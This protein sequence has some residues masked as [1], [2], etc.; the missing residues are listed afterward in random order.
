M[1]IRLAPFTLRRPPVL[2]IVPGAAAQRQIASLS[3]SS[4]RRPSRTTCVTLPSDPR[5]SR[6]TA[7]PL[8]AHAGMLL[9][10]VVS[11]L[12]ALVLSIKVHNE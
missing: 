10:A 11:F 5:C 7:N 1:C 8:S 9:R 2:Q 6:A 12:S 4:Y 3:R